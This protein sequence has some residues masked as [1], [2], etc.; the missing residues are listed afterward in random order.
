L[1]NGRIGQELLAMRSSAAFCAASCAWTASRG[2]SSTAA[3]VRP[4]VAALKK[5]RRSAW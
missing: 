1:N 3:V 4:A 5:S 2:D